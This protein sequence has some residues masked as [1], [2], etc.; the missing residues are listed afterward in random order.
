[1]PASPSF[2]ASTPPT[3]PT[4]SNLGPP[5]PSPP[6]FIFE[7]DHSDPE[8]DDEVEPYASD[9]STGFQDKR[10]KRK[11]SKRATRK[12][13]KSL[14]FLSSSDESDHDESGDFN[15]NP[16]SYSESEDNSEEDTKWT[17]A[18]SPLGN[19]KRKTRRSNPISD[20][21]EDDPD[22]RRVASSTSAPKK[23][24]RRRKGPLSDDSENDLDWGPTKSSV[25][26]TRKKAVH[27]KG[28]RSDS[29]DDPE[30]RQ[31]DSPVEEIK[32]KP[33]GKRGR[34]KKLQV[35][36]FLPAISVPKTTRPRA[37]G[38]GG[39]KA[40]DA[41][42]AL[43]QAIADMETSVPELKTVIKPVR[44]S[45]TKASLKR[46]TEIEDD[47]DEYLFDVK[48]EPK[49]L[50]QNI[51]MSETP[52]IQSCLKDESF[53]ESSGIHNDSSHL[54]SDTGNADQQEEQ[55]VIKAEPYDFQDDDDDDASHTDLYF[56][57]KFCENNIAYRNNTSPS[58]KSDLNSEVEV[59][60]ELRYP[61][62]FCGRAMQYRS[63]L[64]RHLRRVHGGDGVEE[65]MRRLM[66]CRFCE[67]PYSNE[68]SLI[69][70]EKLHDGT[71]K[72]KCNKCE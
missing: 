19:S 64:V 41:A 23:R 12:S 63:H 51:S 55:I 27:R 62:K 39:Q 67:K 58:S 4:P 11:S 31:D 40:Q 22:W 29:D 8:D 15:Y 37:R 60:K 57:R 5:T 3:P 56:S 34:K 33:S 46:Y 25:R 59:K 20:D 49:D 48:S 69:N 36:F 70:H 16:Q 52:Q 42:A 17:K 61:C 21:S 14:Q 1:M 65:V 9:Q 38:L 45:V 43:A 68:L 47:E 18:E 7:S 44:R 26:V 72:M 24:G 6:Q 54:S 10:K 71:S 66:K 50:D 53:A 30:W 2:S 32:K 28:A 13:M 35:A